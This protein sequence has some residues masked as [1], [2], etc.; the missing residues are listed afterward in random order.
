MNFL[1]IDQCFKKRELVYDKY[2]HY[3][4][5]IYYNCYATISSIMIKKLKLITR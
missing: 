5:V 1:Y 4:C 3:S 2:I